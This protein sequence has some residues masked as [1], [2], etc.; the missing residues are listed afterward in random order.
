MSKLNNNHDQ[1]TTS[2]EI[3][4]HE[5]EVKKPTNTLKDF[6]HKFLKKDEENSQTKLQGRITLLQE[7]ANSLE[8][9]L[10]NIEE[11]LK[12]KVDHETYEMIIHVTKPLH[13]EIA[14]IHESNTSDVKAT[15]YEKWGANALYWVKLCEHANC[16]KSVTEAVVKF[17]V[18]RAFEKVEKDIRVIEDYLRHRVLDKNLPEFPLE[19]NQTLETHIQAL[20]QLEEIENPTIES[21]QKWVETVDKKRALHF[22]SAL[23]TIDRS[24]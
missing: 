23:Q 21:I 1:F 19:L 13:K 17:I 5:V 22:E 3:F 12:S 10:R 6:F 8:L 16:E 4:H 14:R 18:N 7:D 2:P 20:R 9:K 11:S 24:F 15:R